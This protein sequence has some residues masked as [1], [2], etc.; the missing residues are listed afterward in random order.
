MNDPT[1]TT[2][3]L[4]SD[5]AS[6]TALEVIENIKK[7]SEGRVD[8]DKYF[9]EVNILESFEVDESMSNEERA[10]ALWK[11]LLF[12]QRTSGQLFLLVGKLLKEFK[13]KEL[14][15][16]LD[17]S[18]FNQFVSSPELA[19]SGESAY[20]Y[21]RVYEFYVE[22]LSLDPETVRKMPL[23]KLSRML[24]MVKEVEQ[25]M[26]K[27]KA[28]ERMNELNTLGLGDLVKEIKKVKGDEKERYR[29]VVVFNYASNLWQ[30]RYYEDRTE[31][32][33]AGKYIEEP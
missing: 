7:A 15:F 21:I 8:V 23:G 26:G 33:N 16:Y 2:E 3:E 6:Q 11:N 31:F 18:S 10:F 20:M 17:Y 19:I 13:E 27:E 28:I 24:P 30:V 14:Y 5:V 25:E 32:V 4:T 22:K 29:P 12:A 9:P 1:G